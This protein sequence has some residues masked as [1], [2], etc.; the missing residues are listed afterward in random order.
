MKKEKSLLC[1]VQWNLK[2]PQSLLLRWQPQ[3]WHKYHLPSLAVLLYKYHMGLNISCKYTSSDILL[4]FFPRQ[5][6]LFEEDAQGNRKLTNSFQS[7]P[8]SRMFKQKWW[9]GVVRSHSPS[10]GLENTNN[11]WWSA[12]AG[13]WRVWPS[14]GKTF[15]IISLEPSS[16]CNPKWNNSKTSGIDYV[17]S[18]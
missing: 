3:Y 2:T 16:S 8:N 1:N 17:A 9:C 4:C 14:L 7:H 11:G 13:R 12:V 5:K 6:Q 18:S 10:F 15:R